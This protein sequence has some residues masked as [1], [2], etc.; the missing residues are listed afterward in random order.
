MSAS[1]VANSPQDAPDPP[2]E[3]PG[4][5]CRRWPLKAALVETG[6]I[7]AVFFVAAGDPVPG[8]NE[9]HYLTRLKHYWDPTWCAGDLF[10]E[11]PDAHLTIVLIAG[12][13]TKLLPLPVVAWAGRLVGWTLLA[14]AWQR[15]SWAANPRRWCSVL[16]AAVWVVGVRWGNF[17]GEWVVGGVEAKVFAYVFVLLALR[18]YLEDRWRAVWVHLGLAT[19]MHA[20]VGGWSILILFALWLAAGTQ[21]QA[22]RSMLPAMTIGA[23]IGLVGV[24]PPIAMNWHTPPEIVAEANRIYVFDRLPHH[25]APLAKGAEWLFNRAACHAT[26]LLL[27]AAATWWARRQR[28]TDQ[29]NLAIAS[30]RVYRLCLFAWGAVV[31]VAVGLSLEAALTSQPEV[32]AKLLRYYWFRLTDVAAPLAVGI[33]LSA[34]IAQ[35]M[36]HRQWQAVLLLLVTMTLLTANLGMTVVARQQMPRAAA[37]RRMQDQAAWLDVCEWVSRRTP[38]EAL[39]LVPRHANSFKWRAER[40]EVVTHKDIPQDAASMVEWRR[41]LHDVFYHPR[42]AGD[43]TAARRRAPTLGHLGATRLR[44]LGETYGADYVLTNN[45]R[46]VSLPVAYENRAYIVYRLKPKEKR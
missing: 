34:V 14:W 31:L 1:H 21:R 40:A 29:P 10:L 19:A 35:G 8:V 15:L 43:P 26:V 45:R 24:A 38:R 7:L 12:W 5:S 3:L 9:Q 30:D 44:T 18:A 11:S 41:R 27:L 17:A 39:F 33:A 22:F 36:I 23:L 2:G 32:A 42:P 25:L 6:L 28:Q 16:A 46:R 13:T 4:Q 20:L 37:D